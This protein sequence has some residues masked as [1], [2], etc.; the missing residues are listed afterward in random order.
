[1]SL[2]LCIYDSYKIIWSWQTPASQILVICDAT[3][4]RKK[5]I[6]NMS[7]KDG[8]QIW[9][10]IHTHLKIFGSDKDFLAR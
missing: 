2:N 6:E 1:M 7:L 10:E 9:K 3:T 8:S 4:S 5:K